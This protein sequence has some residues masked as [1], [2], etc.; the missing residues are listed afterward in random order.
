MT[1]DFSPEVSRRI[2]LYLETHDTAI[3]SDPEIGDILREGI[4]GG[5]IPEGSSVQSDGAG[6]I[7][8]TTPEGD[9][10]TIEVD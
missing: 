10:V 7:V 3:H 4:V 8:A 5:S 9:T 2:D 6:E 1:R